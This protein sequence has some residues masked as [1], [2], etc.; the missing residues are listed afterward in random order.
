MKKIIR[1]FLLAALCAVTLCTVGFGTYAQAADSSDVD[2]KIGSGSTDIKRFYDEANLIYDDNEQEIEQRL[3]NLSDKYGVDVI[4]AFC[5][6]RPSEY[7]SYYTGYDEVWRTQ[8]FACDFY[9]WEDYYHNGNLS[10]DGVIFMLCDDDRTWAI[11]STGILQGAIDHSSTEYIFDQMKSYLSDDLYN[12]AVDEFINQAEIHFEGYR[13][14]KPYIDGKHPQRLFDW[15]LRIVVWIVIGLIIGFIRVGS[16]KN[17]LRSVA[18]KTEASDY[19]VPGSFN[20][21][22]SRDF[23]LY[24]T[25]TRVKRESSSSSGGGSHHSSGGRSFSGG[26]GHY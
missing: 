13:N 6:Q 24:K 25:V 16:M 11:E 23:F 5:S 12:T 20:L 15:V 2:Y 10:A 21:R 22:N 3:R 26:G 14:G 1:S 17:Q 8:Q 4:I 7:D 19:I 9:A 18:V